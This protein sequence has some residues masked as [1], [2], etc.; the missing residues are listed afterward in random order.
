M[1]KGSLEKSLSRFTIVDRIGNEPG[2]VGF[3]NRVREFGITHAA[4]CVARG[5]GVS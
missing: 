3:L 4:K 2:F 5:V 1:C